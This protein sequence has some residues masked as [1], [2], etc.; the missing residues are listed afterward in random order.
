MYVQDDV[1][2]CACVYT[3]ICS[4]FYSSHSDVLGSLVHKSENTITHLHLLNLLHIMHPADAFYT[5]HLVASNKAKRHKPGCFEKKK[6]HEPTIPAY[7]SRIR[8]PATFAKVKEGTPGSRI[9]LELHRLKMF[10]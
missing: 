10:A 7:D 8:N 3:H 1:R 9:T 2:T 6:Q 5:I 4:I